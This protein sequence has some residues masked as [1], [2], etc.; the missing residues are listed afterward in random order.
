MDDGQSMNATLQTEMSLISNINI[1]PNA[2][3]E[4]EEQEILLTN[5]SPKRTNRDKSFDMYRGIIMITMALDH[6][7]ETMATGVGSVFWYGESSDY[8][9]TFNGDLG[10]GLFYFV[11]RFVAQLA[12]PGFMLL[13]GFG[14]VHFYEHRHGK[15]KWSHKYT[16]LHLMLR[17]IVI[18][19]CGFILYYVNLIVFY[20]FKNKTDHIKD[21]GFWWSWDILVALGF[22]M[23]FIAIFVYIENYTYHN[24]IKLFNHV[25]FGHLGMTLIL[26]IFL[27][28]VIST[29]LIVPNYTD[30]CS[31]QRETNGECQENGDNIF[32]R[33]LWLNGSTDWFFS[34]WPLIP[35]MSNVCVGI[36]MGRYTWCAVKYKFMARCIRNYLVFGVITFVLF[37]VIRAVDASGNFG[38]PWKGPNA[39]SPWYGINF[40]VVAKYPPSLTYRLLFISL[41]MFIVYA[42]YI[43]HQK[44]GVGKL[45]KIILVYGNTALFFY[46]LHYILC[47]IVVYR[48]LEWAPQYNRN[49]WPVALLVL[50]SWFGVLLVC[51]P[52]CKWYMRFKKKKTVRSLWKLF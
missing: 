21:E 36:I 33:L 34:L 39:A 45:S 31:K 9:D 32:V 20:D 16:T 11:V 48:V 14:M 3:K 51:Y 12:L 15:I 19:I 23:F 29:E 24:E 41:Q 49:T 30:Y 10:L 47:Y 22:N 4:Q 2:P 17:G 43:Y 18:I 46:I 37:I 1:S 52:C 25:Y 40:F 35:W 44:Y 8:Y 38:K 5:V 13:M 26:F 7:R 50:P 6:L 42:V 28:C 27:F